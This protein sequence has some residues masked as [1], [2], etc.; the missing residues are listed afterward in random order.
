MTSPQTNWQTA[1]FF[2]GVGR[3]LDA[4]QEDDAST[5]AAQ[6]ACLTDALSK[7]DYRILIQSQ[8]IAT[9]HHIL[10]HLDGIYRKIAGRESSLWKI[11][12]HT[13]LFKRHLIMRRGS[14][15]PRHAGLRSQLLNCITVQEIV[16][17]TDG[18]CRIHFE[19][20][21]LFSS[22]RLWFDSHTL[23]NVSHFQ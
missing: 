11:G 13:M 14:W 15:Q 19:K 12:R 17:I 6:G 23:Y 2:R 21:K 8:M 7:L 4:P 10:I 20:F 5:D 16:A 9:T 1:V 18:L 3:S 22:N